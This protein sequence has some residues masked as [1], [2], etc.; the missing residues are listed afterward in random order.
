MASSTSFPEPPRPNAWASEVPVSL[1]V[2]RRSSETRMQ[3]L[4]SQKTRVSAPTPNLPTR[5]TNPNFLFASPERE[6]VDDWS[7]RM[8][9]TP[10]QQ[11]GPIQSLNRG[12]LLPPGYSR[13]YS[14]FSFGSR[15]DYGT[16]N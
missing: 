5:P 14:C 8:G 13:S 4:A 3:L 6:S 10:R 11:T 9:H 1:R 12:A 2:R 15:N 16:G 7:S